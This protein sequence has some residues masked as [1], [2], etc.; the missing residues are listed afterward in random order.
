MIFAMLSRIRQPAYTGDN[1]CTPCTAVNF[2]IAAAV[3]VLVMVVSLPAAGVVFVLSI[4][5]IY[6]RG[7]L[8]PG[9]PRLTKQHFPDWLLRRFDKEDAGAGNPS[10]K[11]AENPESVLVRA[12]ALMEYADRDDLC[13]SE[14]F[15]RRCTSASP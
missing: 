8:V 10:R 13:L 11:D 2:A 1:R 3:S 4:G 9:T 6:L 15:R 5:T 7:Y 14:R 12:G